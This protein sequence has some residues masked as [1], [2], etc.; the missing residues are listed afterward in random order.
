MLDELERLEYSPRPPV[1]QPALFAEELPEA[2]T[3][4]ASAPSAARR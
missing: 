2:P 3:P 1:E 4:I